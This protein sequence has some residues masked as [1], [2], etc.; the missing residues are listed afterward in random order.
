MDFFISN[1]IK[2]LSKK[3]LPGHHFYSEEEVSVLSYPAV[4]LDPIDG[5]REF[6]K[7]VPQCA[8]SM[9][10]MVN[11][12]I[13]DLRNFAWIYNPL[14]GFELSSDGLLS[15]TYSGFYRDNVDTKP[16][17][18]VSRS[19]FSKNIFDEQTRS[20][21]NLLPVGSIAFKLALL[22]SGTCDFVLSLQPKSLWDIA[23]GTLL[24]K[25]QGID[26]YA[27]NGDK[28]TEFTSERY[29]CN[30]LWCRASLRPHFDH[31]F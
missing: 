13:E 2:N 26:F 1:T 20:K 9:A 24:C 31:I 10:I 5:T 14:S 11:N 15:H 21:F 7:L 3:Y 23:A 30:L 22:A 6:A 18:L 4:I 19:E 27:F 25:Q 28:V 16:C 17:G 12:K 8:L 29:D